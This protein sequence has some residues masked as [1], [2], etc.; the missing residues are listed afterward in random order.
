M[1]S[2]YIHLNDSTQTQA[3]IICI[4]HS[5]GYAAQYSTWANFLPGE[6]DCIVCERPGSGLR[7]QEERCSDWTMVVEDAWD[8]IQDKIDMPYILFGHSLGGSIAFELCKKIHSINAQMPVCLAIGDREAPSYPPDL[9][10]YDLSDELFKDTLINEY[11]LSPEIVEN[12]ELMSFFLPA[13]RA[14]FALADTYSSS[15]KPFSGVINCPIAV[16]RPADTNDSVAAQ[17][18]WKNET[19]ADFQMIN[20]SG[21]HF[22]VFEHAQEFLQK[23]V[24][25]FDKKY[26]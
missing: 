13:L 21:D 11:N 9:V 3:R 15:Q 26:N 6:I 14:D 22:F 4:Y 17:T 25:L 18:G 2:K 19:T 20:M 5:G 10:R 12:E 8:I 24:A 1:P 7:I 16:F 23:L